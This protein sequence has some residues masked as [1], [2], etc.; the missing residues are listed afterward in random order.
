[1]M[2][3]PAIAKKTFDQFKDNPEFNTLVRFVLEHLRKMTNPF[4][5]VDFIHRA[6]DDLNE[7]VFAHP[8]IKEMSPCKEGCSACCHTQVSVT[9]DEAALLARRISEGVEIDLERLKLQVTAGDD[10]SA[11]YKMNFEERKCI[12]LGE[13]GGCRVYNDRPSVCR[14]N[15]VIGDASQC[16]TTN[17]IQRTQLIKTPK[18]DMVIYASFYNAKS[19]GALPHMVAKALGLR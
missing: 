12:F 10:D 19:S 14:T 18:A 13:D 6:I 7:E 5:R 15:A 8:L 1:M 11:F 16:D 2:N 3:V 4:Q 17:G 9:D